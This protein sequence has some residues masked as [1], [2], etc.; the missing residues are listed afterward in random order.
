MWL[1][2]LKCYRSQAN[3][4]KFLGEGV[5]MLGTCKP[6]YIC[7]WLHFVFFI[8]GPLFISLQRFR[9]CICICIYSFH[10]LIWPICGA[11]HCWLLSCIFHFFFIHASIWLVYSERVA[12]WVMNSGVWPLSFV[13]NVV[14][15]CWFTGT[16]CKACSLETVSFQ[17]KLC[18]F[19]PRN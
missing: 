1:L 16:Y 8:T 15:P 14:R 17:G 7:L 18:P 12:R 13:V 3:W 6:Y 11:L 4:N 10:K 19:R 5:W 9:T 2:F